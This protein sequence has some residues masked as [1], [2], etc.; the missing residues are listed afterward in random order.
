[1]SKSLLGAAALLALVSVTGCAA[2]QPAAA[3]PE[4]LVAPEISFT[5]DPE[6]AAQI[7]TATLCWTDS[8]EKSLIRLL[9]HTLSVPIACTNQPCPKTSGNTGSVG[10]PDLSTTPRAVT[11]SLVYTP[12]NHVVD[13]QLTLA[14]KAADRG[15]CGP[16]VQGVAV[17]VGAD[18][19]AHAA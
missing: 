3:C 15:H 4:I 5:V 10:V 9:P 7:S 8:C 17:V 19:K 13:Q 6:V 1:M 16:S 14:P 12:E 2:E 18:G 11:V